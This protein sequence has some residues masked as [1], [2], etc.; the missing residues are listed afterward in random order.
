MH[1]RAADEPVID[2]IAV[3]GNLLLPPSR[4]GHGVAEQ[5]RNARLIAAGI[6][7]VVTTGARVVVTHG[8]GTQVGAMLLRSE[9]SAGRV[10]AEPLDFCVAATQGEI[11]YVLEDALRVELWRTTAPYPVVTLLTQVLVSPE[12]E[13]QRPTKPIGPAYSERAAREKAAELGWKICGDDAHGYRRIVPSP[14]PLKIVQELAIRTLL[15]N[16]F[17]VVALGGGGIPVTWTD[18]QLR[19]TETVVD[20]D[21]SSALLAAHLGADTLVF[22][23]GTDCVYLDYDSDH[24]R[25]IET[26]TA[27]EMRRYLEAGEFHAGS[28]GPKVE[29][30]LAFISNGGRRAIIAS[31]A[32]LHGALEGRSGTCIAAAHDRREVVKQSA[33]SDGRVEPIGR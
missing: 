25:P 2:V 29:A 24:P 11:G 23:T 32:D 10:Y 31:P 18:G 33:D 27:A 17:V 9:Y 15:Q 28:M 6:A 12:A 20:K 13:L 1:K 14:A 3:G 30:A 8:N 5:R 4:A 21:A 7:E 26:V 16:G 22:L 19:G